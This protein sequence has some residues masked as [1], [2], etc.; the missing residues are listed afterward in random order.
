[1]TALLLAALSSALLPT[2]R[3]PSALSSALLPTT[4]EP[5]VGRR[6]ALLS[7]AAATLLSVPAPGWA[8][9]KKEYIASLASGYVAPKPKEELLSEVKAS[10]LLEGGS[11][12][13]SSGALIVDGSAR[14][15][16]PVVRPAS[17]ISAGKTNKS[18]RITKFSAEGDQTVAHVQ[19]S[20]DDGTGGALYSGAC[21][22]V[23]TGGD[24]WAVDQDLYPLDNPKVY[25]LL[26][27]KRDIYGSVFMELDQG[28]IARAAPSKPL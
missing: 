27:P 1:M 7:A 11:L 20:V 18:V 28:F 19:Y 10:I 25:V 5:A 13:Y 21:R 14:S 8:L 4:R 24:S 22:V 2:V 15:E 12:K 23:N 3:E 26:Q 9:T 17:E 16:K 6:G